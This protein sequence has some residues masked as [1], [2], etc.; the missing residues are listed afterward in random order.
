MRRLIE[1]RYPLREPDPG[2]RTIMIETAE[3]PVEALCYNF[4]LERRTPLVIDLHGG[5]FVLGRAADDEAMN[6]GI[7]A[8][9]GFRV[10][11][12]EYPL[13]PE[14]PFPAAITAVLASA[15]HF[16]V[17]AVRY[18]IDAG[19]IGIVGH[20]AGANLATVACLEAREAGIC[21]RCQILDYPPLDLDADPFGKPAPEG[22]IPPGTARMFNACY[23]APGDRADRRVSPLLAGDDALRG[24]PPALLVLAGRDSLHDEGVAYAGRLRAAGVETELA[25]YPDALHGF[26]LGDS[27]DARDALGRMVGFLKARLG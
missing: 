25:D 15:R 19:R 26:T 21:F 17:E 11:S 24:L 23:A 16:A 5:G 3:G 4:G 1:E 8:A 6:L 7:A 10:A 18:G 14:H 22:C 12:V 13:A 2:R 9:T 20:S 27:A